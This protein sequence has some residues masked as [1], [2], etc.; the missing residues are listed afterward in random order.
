MQTWYQASFVASLGLQMTER[1]CVLLSQIAADCPP[2]CFPETTENG[3]LDRP[4]IEPPLN[5]IA[6]GKEGRSLP[7]HVL[8]SM[9]IAC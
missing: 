6:G 8:P 3:C 1:T 9:I 4:G 7:L 2:F 5:R